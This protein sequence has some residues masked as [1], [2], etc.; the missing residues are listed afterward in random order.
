[1]LD[2]QY[3]GKRRKFL[4]KGATNRVEEERLPQ[5]GKS[6]VSQWFQEKPI[7]PT[8]AES[9]MGRPQRRLAACLEGES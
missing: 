8:H 2:V 7:S 3:A 6:R 4:N 5:T 1:M 9:I